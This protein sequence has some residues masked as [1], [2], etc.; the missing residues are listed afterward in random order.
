MMPT[1]P[2]IT[3]RDLDTVANTSKSGEIHNGYHERSTEGLPIPRGDAQR[4]VL[5][6]SLVE[7]GQQIL[8][9]MCERIEAE[10]PTDLDSLY[11]IT[12]SSTEEFNALGEE[13]EENDSELETAARECIGA[14]FD[15]I[16]KAYG[17]DADVEELIST[18]EW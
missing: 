3:F 13:F 10:L 12:Q 7:K 5:P 16:A 15:F 17:F 14:D 2:A 1:P 18:R 4:Q 9:R 6:P 8:V 11:K